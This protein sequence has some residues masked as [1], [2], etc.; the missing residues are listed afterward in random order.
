MAFLEFHYH[1]DA[2]RMGVNVN[3]ILPENRKSAIG[4][5]SGAPEGKCKTVYLLHGLSDD[6]TA[7][8]R[9]TSIER[10]AAEYGIAVVMPCVGRSWYTDTEYGQNY[11]TFVAEELPRVCQGYFRPISD[12][13]EDNF[14]VGQSMG[15]YGAFK[16]AFTYPDKFAACAALS[17][18]LDIISRLPGATIEQWQDFFG[19]GFS[20]PE[21]QRDEKCDLFAI[22]DKLKASGEEPP[23]IFMW[24]GTEDFLINANR[25]F[26]KHLSA[27]GIEH[28]YTESEGN[29]S[30]KYWDEHIK[31][32]LKFFFG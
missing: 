16:T 2:L 12:K 14:I 4:V 29:H 10:Y 31:D 19:A 26:D 22:A 30:W 3:I 9:R 1:S 17:G 32:V 20:S 21:M 18:S 7:W 23:R 8:M 5:R 25:K 27:L 6:H 28:T 11:F 13:R 15:G 24:C